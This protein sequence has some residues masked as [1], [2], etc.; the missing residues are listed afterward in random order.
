MFDTLSKYLSL[1]LENINPY[2]NWAK[3]TEILLLDSGHYLS[4]GLMQRGRKQLQK[5][6]V[7]V[8]HSGMASST[9]LISSLERPFHRSS[10]T[11]RSGSS[12]WWYQ[13]QGEV[14]QLQ[15]L[16]GPLG[17]T[18]HPPVNR[19]PPRVCRLFCNLRSK[20]SFRPPSGRSF[21]SVWDIAPWMPLAAAPQR[22]YHTP[23]DLRRPSVSGSNIW[24]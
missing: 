10:A 21:T 11:W 16:L 14:G 7:D 24:L 20:R 3:T 19:W 12:L 22:G 23:A 4:V 5:A 8:C 2:S 9:C 13:T 18:L 15:L 1:Y 17:T 6:D